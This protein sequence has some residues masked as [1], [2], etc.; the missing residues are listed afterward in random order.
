MDVRR[1]RL[2]TGRTGGRRRS[3]RGRTATRRCRCVHAAWSGKKGKSCRSSGAWAPAP[4]LGGAA[5]DGAGGAGCATAADASPQ[6]SATGARTVGDQSAGDHQ[7]PVERRAP[8][9]RSGAFDRRHLDI[10]PASPRRSRLRP[11]HPAPVN[12]TAAAATAVSHQVILV[13]DFGSQY[14][15]LIA[16]RLRE[17]HVYSE[18][19]PFDTPAAEIARRQPSGIILSGGPLSVTEAG[20]PHCDYALFELG[21]PVLGICYGMQLM[22][23]R[24]GG[25]L[26]PVVAPRV[27]PCRCDGRR[28]RTAVRRPGARR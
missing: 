27:R 10:I 28:G 25:T 22:T 23:Q 4:A 19:I 14:T 21:V 11:A 17:L 1:R 16:R 9:T 13:L 3:P 20:A 2:T 18:I 24:L 15:Q 6:T 5:V 26:T 12:A 8:T 7:E